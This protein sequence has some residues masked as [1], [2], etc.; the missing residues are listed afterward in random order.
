MT[1]QPGVYVPLGALFLVIYILYSGRLSQDSAV[2]LVLVKE[3][4][5]IIFCSRTVWLCGYW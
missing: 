1:H 5:L 2:R 4:S 3:F